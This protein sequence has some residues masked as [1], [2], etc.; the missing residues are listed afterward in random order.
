VNDNDKNIAKEILLAMMEKN[1]GELYR[2][3]GSEYAETNTDIV[4]KAYQNILKY[5]SNQE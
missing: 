4:G 2:S 3:C 5:V 1:L